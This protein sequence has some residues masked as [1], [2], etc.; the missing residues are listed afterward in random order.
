MMPCLEMSCLEVPARSR[1]RQ[2]RRPVLPPSGEVRFRRLTEAAVAATFGVPLGAL[3]TPRRRPADAA[4]ARQVTMYLVHT[5]LGV[6][7]GAVGRMLKIDPSTAKHGCRVVEGRRD[8][9]AIDR[10]IEMLDVICREL[11]M[12]AFVASRGRR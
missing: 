9:P 12:S 10:L 1:T 8:D 3:R 4:F 2:P 7:Y 5:V 6:N 11:A